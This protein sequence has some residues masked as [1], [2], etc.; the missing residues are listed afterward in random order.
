MQLTN[1]T[2]LLT[3][4]S[5]GLGR[6]I[7]LELGRRGARLALVARDQKGLDEVRQLIAG[8]RE[9]IATSHEAIARA[10]ERIG[11]ALIRRRQ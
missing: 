2:V 7:A 4:A 1:S 11:S 5:R 3:G 9:A 8:S 6:L 10:D